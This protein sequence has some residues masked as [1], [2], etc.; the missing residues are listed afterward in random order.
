MQRVTKS[1]RSYTNIRAVAKKKEKISY[2]LIVSCME[3]FFTSDRNRKRDWKHN[4]VDSL[5]AVGLDPMTTSEYIFIFHENHPVSC[6]HLLSLS[7][8]QSQ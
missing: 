5:W 6:F 7:I 4:E 1:W 8:K 3:M 2:A